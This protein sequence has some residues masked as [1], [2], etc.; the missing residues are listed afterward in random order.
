MQG[1]SKILAEPICLSASRSLR[2]HPPPATPP[3]TRHPSSPPTSYTH[4]P[5]LPWSRPWHQPQ[6]QGSAA[7][8]PPSAKTHSQTSTLCQAGTA[9]VIFW[10]EREGKLRLVEPGR[11]ACF[12]QRVRGRFP[13][14]LCPQNINQLL[15]AYSYPSRVSSLYTDTHTYTNMLKHYFYQNEMLLHVLYGLFHLILGC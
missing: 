1:L 2:P 14:I 12:S 5:P 6:Q 13:L 4:S 3:A 15:K 7:S 11:V 8:G 9:T 10:R